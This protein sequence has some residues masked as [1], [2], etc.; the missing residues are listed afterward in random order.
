MSEFTPPH[1]VASGEEFLPLTTEYADNGTSLFFDATR[2]SGIGDTHAVLD[3][4]SEID[5]LPVPFHALGNPMSYELSIS[6]ISRRPP[7]PHRLRCTVL[8]DGEKFVSEDQPLEDYD[9][10]SSPNHPFREWSFVD[11]KDAQGVKVALG[12]SEQKEDWNK[13]RVVLEK[14]L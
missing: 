12:L 4:L 6:I 8:F 1:E 3:R 10:T 13:V 7:Y 5:P 2:V 9:P 14:V 11:W